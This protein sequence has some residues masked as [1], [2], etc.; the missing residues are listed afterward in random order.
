VSDRNTT[1]EYAALEVSSVNCSEIETRSIARIKY[2]R[3][4]N[5][6]HNFI[7]QNCQNVQKVHE[8]IVLRE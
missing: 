6:L 3:F 5:C 1:C 8:M 7:A 2:D 4:V